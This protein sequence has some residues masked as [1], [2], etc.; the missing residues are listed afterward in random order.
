[1]KR[2]L[3]REEKRIQWVLMNL[4]LSGSA[5]NTEQAAKIA[6]GEYVL[7][8]SLEEH[9]LVTKLLDALTLMEQLLGLQEELCTKTLYRF[10]RVFSGG[11]AGNF[12]KRTPVLAHLSHSP[13]LPQEIEEEL[14]RMFRAL[15]GHPVVNPL[16]AAA[17]VHHELMRIYPFDQCN[18]LIARA[19]MEY[20]LLYLGM[21]L[22][23]ITLSE[24]AYNSALA[25][26]MK[27]GKDTEL[28]VNLRLNKLM[29]E[30]REEQL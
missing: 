30:S 19:A 28:L 4:R 16:E 11:E 8:A 12:R 6:A 17:F 10:Y 25:N 20:E 26:Y 14:T 18:E 13:V 29:A 21:D 3:N 5:M 1:M 7:E 23:P 15:H 9:L 27:F 2:D 22:Y 24:S